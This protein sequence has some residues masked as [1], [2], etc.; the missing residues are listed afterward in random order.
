MIHK[1][2]PVPLPILGFAAI[3]IIGM[4]LTIFSLLSFFVR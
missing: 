4:A 3:L 1:P 2:D